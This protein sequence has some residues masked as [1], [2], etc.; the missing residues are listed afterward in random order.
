MTFE[1]AIEQTR[2]ARWCGWPAFPKELPSMRDSK[3][4]QLRAVEALRAGVPNRDVVRQL[5]PVQATVGRRFEA[6][7]KATAEPF[8]DGLPAAPTPGML[9]EGDFGTGKSHWLEYFRHRALE[10]NFVCSRIVL[11]KETPLHDSSLLLRAAAASAV[12]PDRVGPALTEL[13]LSY[14]PE[15][16]P[17]YRELFEWVHRTPDLDPRLAATLYLFEHGAD[18]EMREKAMAEWAGYPMAVADLRGA[19]KAAGS[20]AYRIGRPQAGQTAQR[21]EFLSRFFRSAGYAGWVILF[22]EAEMISRYSV[23]QRGRAYAHLAALLNLMPG[24]IPGLAA[25]FTIT[26]DYA[27]QVLM[28]RKNDLGNLLPRLA[29]TCDAPLAPAADTGMRAIQLKGIDLRPPTPEQ[30]SAIYEATR[31]LYAEAYDWQPPDERENRREYLASTGWRQYVRTWITTWDLRR[32][33]GY[34]ANPVIDRPQMSYE[35][36]EDIQHG[37]PPDGIFNDD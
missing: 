2:S 22:D 34:A 1:T 16:A 18:D 30:V 15:R 35:E 23:R 37:P 36:D 11:N 26:K 5:P 32:L 7:L 14:D 9:L 31:A 29:G 27:G 20:G 25:I 17:G 28:G 8:G 13:A 10:E 21:M 24:S 19:L 4:D 33:Y 3:V 12:A 6:L